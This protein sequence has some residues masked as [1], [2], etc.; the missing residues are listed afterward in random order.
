MCLS[1]HRIKLK[2]LKTNI[3]QNL[4]LFKLKFSTLPKTGDDKLKSKNTNVLEVLTQKHVLIQKNNTAN[5]N[6]SLF[7][8]SD[9]F[10]TNEE[11]SFPHNST[12]NWLT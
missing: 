7:S 12:L 1:K 5:D 10:T 11:I 6:F 3:F 2:E 9:F 4:Y 8:K